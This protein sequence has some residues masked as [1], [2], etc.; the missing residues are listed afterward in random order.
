MPW[1]VRALSPSRSF[2]LSRGAVGS[3]ILYQSRSKPTLSL[4]ILHSSHLRIFFAV[5]SEHNKSSVEQPPE[6]NVEREMIV[7]KDNPDGL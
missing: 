2:D 3:Q 5:F 7:G 6:L 4:P 1:W